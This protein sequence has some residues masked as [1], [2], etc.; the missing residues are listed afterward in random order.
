MR[1]AYF[2]CPAGASGDMILGALASAGAPLGKIVR[3]VRALGLPKLAL[4][5]QTAKRGGFAG[6]QVNVSC[7]GGTRRE[8]LGRA[9][10]TKRA[11]GI[12]AGIIAAGGRILRRLL[13]AESRAHGV[14]AKH[15]HLHEIED[16]DTIADAYGSLLALH[17]LG[18]ERIYVST[19]AL[20]S[21]RVEASHGVMPVPAPGTAELLKGRRVSFGPAVG[22]MVTPTAAAIFAE[23]AAPGPVPP[24]TV[25]KVGSGAGS[26]NP[27][28]MANLLRVFIGE[29]REPAGTE[30]V[31]QL[32]AEVD[33]MN[34]QL[35]EAWMERAYREGA[36]EAWTHPVSMKKGRTGLAMIALARP[37]GIEAVARAFLEETSTLG[38]RLAPMRRFALPR[39][40]SV[41]RT[42]F[43]PVRVKLG[44]KG[45]SWHAVPEYRDMKALAARR[46]VP[47][48]LVMEEV[49]RVL[50]HSGG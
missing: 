27:A 25:E 50:P 14:C 5:A 7:P 8:L 24:F 30:A 26:R 6:M 11:R 13:A 34:P 43:G 12:P 38:V 31:F 4:R 32:E 20:G 42:K 18:V 17:M 39:R 46:G 37:G 3:A 2:D 28:G 21:G 36:L 16:V 45:D 9:M 19:L 1:I 15:A 40:E 44:G 41:L 47:L 29:A 22:E 49:R 23:I 35:A 10:N 48:R 33:D